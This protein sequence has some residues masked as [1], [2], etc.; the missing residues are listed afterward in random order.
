MKKI[1]FGIVFF[2]LFLTSCS[3]KEADDSSKL[4]DNN[5]VENSEISSNENT[6]QEDTIDNSNISEIVD[7]NKS[8]KKSEV[9]NSKDSNKNNSNKKDSNGD[10]STDKKETLSIDN[11][12]E[13]VKDY[14]INGQESKSE[15][16]KIKWS[17]TFLNQVD[18][19][20]LY[21]QY[22]SNGGKA[23]DLEEFAKYITS[24]A[25]IIK[26]WKELFEK[27]LYN[28]YEEKVVRLEHLEGDLY[29]AYIKKD[30][31][32]VPYVVV[33]SRTGYFHG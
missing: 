20:S 33:S 13:K 28:K 9:N 16:N 31:K 11:I 17:E 22:I 7:N 25:P 10:S 29:Q 32:E 14:I 24:N 21:K 18:I 5:Q 19:N 6:K 4:V 15:V 2:S 30:G 27:D 3:S 26:N 8:D 23:D 12:D 1:L